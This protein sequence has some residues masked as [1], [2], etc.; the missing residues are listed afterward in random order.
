LWAVFEFRQNKNP[1]LYRKR[2]I[3]APTNT[4]MMVSLEILM[5]TS[6]TTPPIKRGG[7]RDFECSADA[8]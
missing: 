3:A 1:F 8:I 7:F 6:I 5:W 4:L 2:M